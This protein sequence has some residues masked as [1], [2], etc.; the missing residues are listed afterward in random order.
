MLLS[1]SLL[2]GFGAFLCALSTPELQAGDAPE[3]QFFQSSFLPQS[4]TVE[5]GG[6][7]RF[8]WVRGEHT[9]TSGRPDGEAGSIDEPGA[10][11]DVELNEANPVFDYQLDGDVIDGVAFFDR[12]HPAQI[13]FIQ[14]DRDEE[15]VRVGV[16]DNEYLP[17]VVFIFAGDTV[18]WEH[19]PMEAFHTVTS[20]RSSAPEDDPGALFDAESSEARPTFSYRFDDAGEYHYFCRP[21]EHLDMVGVVFVQSRFVRG[22]ASGDGGV[23]IADMV[24]VLNFLFTAA[25]PS[26]NCRDAFDVNDDGG[27]DIADPVFGLNFLFSGGPGIPQPFPFSGGDRTEDDLRCDA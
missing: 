26:S 7:V 2:V 3:V 9:V 13:G 4:V 11:F 1:R 12:N 10:L 18:L 16:V 19:E 15:T 25:G 6:I 24:S 14:V 8:R 21:H 27:V 22:D 17:P 23:D 5:R 20:G